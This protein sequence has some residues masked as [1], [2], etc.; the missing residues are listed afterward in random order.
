M[1]YCTHYDHLLNEEE[2]YY[3][4]SPEYNNCC[5]CLINAKGPMTQEQVAK[6]LRSNENVDMCF[7]T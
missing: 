6:Y 1:K 7:R 5:F 4:D 2:R 3:V